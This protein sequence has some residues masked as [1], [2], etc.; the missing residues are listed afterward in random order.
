MLCSWG[1]VSRFRLPWRFL[2]AR[3]SASS[4]SLVPNEGLL[5]VTDP[6]ALALLERSELDPPAPLPSPPTPLGE[7]LTPPGMLLPGGVVLLCGLRAADAEAAAGKDDGD[8]ADDV[9]DDDKDAKGRS[10]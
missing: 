1:L 2:S 4:P 5:D 3:F 9:E 6:A 10:P 7:D 8:D